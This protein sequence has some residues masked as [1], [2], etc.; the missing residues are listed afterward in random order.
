MNTP[1]NSTPSAGLAP[2]SRFP[3]FT[4]IGR[5]IFSRKMLFVL[6]GLATLAGLLLT[7]VN[8]RGR[9]AWTQCRQQAEARGL[10]LDAA[11]FIPPPIPEN[12]NLAS[13]PLFASL[14]DYER[15]EA[16]SSGRGATYEVR[17]RNTNSQGRL[18]QADL[19]RSQDLRR[20]PSDLPPDGPIDFKAWQAF[21][22]G[23][24]RFPQ[25]ASSLSA[26][27]TVLAAL[28]AFEPLLAELGRDAQTRTN[29]RFPIHYSEP[30]VE[31]LLPHLS[32]LKQLVHILRLRASASLACGRAE[33]AF[34]DILLGFQLTDALRGDPFVISHAVRV[35]LLRQPIQALK[36]GL[37]GGVWSDAQLETVQKR[38]AAY[39]LPAELRRSL[40]SEMAF[41]L[42]TIDQ[43]S[44]NIALIESDTGGSG[45]GSTLRLALWRLFPAGWIARNKVTLVSFYMEHA[46]P[47]VD[48]P[49]RRI[50]PG[51][52]E[53]ASRAGNPGLSP[54]NL[55]AR[56]LIPSATAMVSRSAHTQTLIDQ[57]IIACALERFR[58]AAGRYPESLDALQPKY[59]A[60]LPRDL[61]TGQPYRYR[62]NGESFL[63]YSVGW[64]ETD[65]GGQTVPQRGAR[66]PGAPTG[67]WV[68]R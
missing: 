8:W 39:D 49:A 60:D 30:F 3:T 17:W 12:I 52:A 53:Q 20:A 67:D 42:K 63:L 16:T 65:E 29:A 5:W 51:P 13:A 2:A 10:S 11:T 62:L 31:V 35:S 6:A 32:R 23:N 45:H 22:Q 50:R 40:E 43:I 37:Q 41:G 48:L 28:A 33:P 4:R 34:Q 61:F 21:F 15:V 36:E 58:H 47:A 24:T 55:I 59:A 68:W 64:N 38:L 44:E 14:L 57:A 54:G 9:A 18:D 19:R 25:A 26:P 27:E 46:L 66:Q 56:L 1:D 7:L